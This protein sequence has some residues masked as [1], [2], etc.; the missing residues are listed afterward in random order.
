MALIIYPTDGYDSFVSV[1]EATTYI[2]TLTTQGAAWEAL[3]EATQ[4]VYLRIACRNILM[5][6]DQNVNPLPDP[7]PACLGES[8]SL[9]A[10]Q[11]LTYGISATTDVGDTGAIKKQKVATLE[12]EYY[13]TASGVTTTIPLVPKMAQPCLQSL[14]YYISPAITG[15]SQTTLGRS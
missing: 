5:G 8:Q 11:D 12:I 10:S 13:D 15:L 14:G 1:E 6:I 2:T 4:E 3:D 7:A 9:M